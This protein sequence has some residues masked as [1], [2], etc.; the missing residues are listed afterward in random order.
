MSG[1]VRPHRQQP[2][3]LH[4]LW[5]SPGKNT[6]VGCHFFGSLLGFNSWI[7][8]QTS[9]LFVRQIL[10]SWYLHT[11][12]KRK[13]ESV[14]HSGV[15]NSLWPHGLSMKFSRQEY[16]SGL[17]FPSPRDIPDPGIKPR[18]LALQVEKLYHLSYQGDQTYTMSELKTT[19]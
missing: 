18:S 13:C 14:N 9:G 15:T 4:H 8:M 7:F 3:R 16:W 2:T 6:G 19:S 12:G 10:N 1:S 5:D 17:P 11:G